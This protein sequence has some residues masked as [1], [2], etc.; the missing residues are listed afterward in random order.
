MI[1]ANSASGQHSTNKMHHS[2]K[3]NTGKS[4]TQFHYT[5]FVGTKFEESLSH[6]WISEST[7]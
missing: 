4:S 2:R 5:N 1:N 6:G 7:V 3:V